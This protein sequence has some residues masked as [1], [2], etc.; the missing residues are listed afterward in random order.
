MKLTE[1]FIMRDRVIK[2]AMYNALIKDRQSKNI[3]EIH[4]LIDIVEGAFAAGN[5]EWKE[6]YFAILFSD[7]E[8]SEVENLMTK[9]ERANIQRAQENIRKQQGYND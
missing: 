6:D 1:L 3:R 4:D 7:K 9:E 2:E 8:I 5:E